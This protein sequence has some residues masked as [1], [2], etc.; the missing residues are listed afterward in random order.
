MHWLGTGLGRGGRYIWYCRI[1]HGCDAVYDVC[2]YGTEVDPEAS[3]AQGCD[4]E[5]L[6]SLNAQFTGR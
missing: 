4:D 1:D 6:R 3:D 5:H 2:L